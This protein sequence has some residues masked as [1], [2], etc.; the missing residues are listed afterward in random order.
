MT[1]GGEYAMRASRSRRSRKAE[2][3]V[4]FHV[5]VHRVYFGAQVDKDIFVEWPPEDANT[6]RLK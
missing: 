6:N 3:I 2:D 4:L 5:D 1:A